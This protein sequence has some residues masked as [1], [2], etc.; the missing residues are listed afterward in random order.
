MTQKEWDRAVKWGMALGMS[1]E[2]AI[3]AALRKG[4]VAEA[5]NHN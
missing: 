5:E 2:E 1:P 4:E 3:Q